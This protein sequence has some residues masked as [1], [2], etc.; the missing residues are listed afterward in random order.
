MI[1]K[2]L[3]IEIIH[4]IQK[5]NIVD[6]EISKSLEKVCG[7]RILFNTENLIYNSLYEMLGEIFND[8]ES[9]YIGWWLFE[10]TEKIIYIDN[11]EVGIKTSEQL[12]DFLITYNLK[13]SFTNK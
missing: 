2:K 1:S 13:N 7:S 3:F 11:K 10:D 6:Y 12:Y 9:D 8:E 4:N 5:Q